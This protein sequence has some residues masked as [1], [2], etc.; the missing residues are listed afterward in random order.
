MSKLFDSRYGKIEVEAQMPIGDWLWPGEL[1]I[2]TRIIFC[3]LK[4]H[5]PLLFFLFHVAYFQLSGCCH[6]M[7]SMVVG[8]HQEKLTL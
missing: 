1:E 3:R 8:Q 7:M 6:H 2:I 5:F 4:E